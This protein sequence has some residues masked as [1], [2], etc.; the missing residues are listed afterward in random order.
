M[1]I[2]EWNLIFINN[3]MHI[4]S[5]YEYM[6]FAIRLIMKVRGKDLRVSRASREKSIRGLLQLS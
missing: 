5:T 6:F 3:E 2:D 4:N 1:R